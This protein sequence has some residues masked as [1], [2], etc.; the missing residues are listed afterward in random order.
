MNIQKCSLSLF[1]CHCCKVDVSGAYDSLPHNK[2]IEVI[3]QVL[4]PVLNKVFTIRRFA[5]I[6]ADSHEGLKKTFIRQVKEMQNEHSSACI[7]TI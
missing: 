3:N 4:K 1:L 2:L 6:W 7:L 5:K